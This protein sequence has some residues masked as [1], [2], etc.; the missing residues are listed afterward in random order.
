MK[1][2]AAGAATCFSTGIITILTVTSLMRIFPYLENNKIFNF[3]LFPAT[4]LIFLV[5]GLY[6]YK[7]YF[8]D[9]YIEILK[10]TNANCDR[11]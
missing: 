3:L 10:N 4:P 9:K 8:Y 11:N 7:L 6:L 5:F 2:V 1:L